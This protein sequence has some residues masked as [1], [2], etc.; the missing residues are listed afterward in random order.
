MLLFGS[1]LCYVFFMAGCGDDD[2]DDGGWRWYKLGWLVDDDD[3][4]LFSLS[5][6]YTNLFSSFFCNVSNV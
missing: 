2:E 3:V 6:I 4:I 5:Q 1:F